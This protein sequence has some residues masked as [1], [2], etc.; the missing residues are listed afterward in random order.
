MTRVSTDPWAGLWALRCAVIDGAASVCA[1][2]CIKSTSVS[3]NLRAAC[4]A[5]PLHGGPPRR[6][7]C[8]LLV[9]RLVSSRLIGCVVSF[10]ALAFGKHK[11]EAGRLWLQ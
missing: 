3:N 4:N 9:S 10:S 8:T 2:F 6:F 7:V 11:P 1:S 5:R